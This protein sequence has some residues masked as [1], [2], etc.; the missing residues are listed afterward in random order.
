MKNLL[1]PIILPILLF[2]LF[3]IYSCAPVREIQAENGKIDLS[4]WD[5]NSDGVVELDGKWEFYWGKLLYHEDFISSADN[6]LPL[7]QE[8]STLW[9]NYMIDKK[10]LPNSGY[11][12]FRLLVTLPDKD[13]P[14]AF[15]IMNMST[16]YNLYVDGKY[17]IG[18]GKVGTTKEESVPRWQTSIGI[19]IPNSDRMEIIFQKR[20]AQGLQIIQTMTFSLFNQPLGTAKAAHTRQGDNR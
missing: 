18:N 14:Y 2:Y 4:S 10:P 16:A 19:Y 1:L 20:M 3:F 6:S 11:A 5:F 8:V 17:I 13:A 9:S 7:Y 15:K 12:T